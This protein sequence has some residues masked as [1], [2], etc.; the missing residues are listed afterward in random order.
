[1]SPR[2]ALAPA[3]ALALVSACGMF[4]GADEETGSSGAG[5]SSGVPTGGPVGCVVVGDCPAPALCEAAECAD[6]LC[7]Y[8]PR[9]A[10]ERDDDAPG[11]C[12]RHVCDGV[13]GSEL[14]DDAADVPDDGNSC[15]DDRCGAG[16][17]PEN[18]ARAPGSACDGGFCHADVTCQPC[19]E[20]DTCVD[21]SAAEPNETQS[22]AHALPQLRDD[23]GLAYLC[24]AL[25]GPGD[26]DWFT[27]DTLDVVLG[28]VAPAVI[29]TPEGPRV[30]VYFQCKQ[31]ATSVVCPEE[32]VADNAPL[33]QQGCCGPGSF[34]PKI[35]C[36]GAAADATLWLRVAHA[37]TLPDDPPPPE[38]LNYQLGYE[39]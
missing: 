18:V 12:R 29:T 30:C 27:L 11:D 9:G 19:P 38:C 3:L 34:A 32:A 7:T 20:R 14:V 28:D 13:G 4:A 2:L 25:G 22:K 26:V 16:G 21:D 6:S 5:S 33:G 23:A 31:G 35:A 8:T 15:T 37:P 10:G 39:Y 17:E 1:M 36:D 24:E